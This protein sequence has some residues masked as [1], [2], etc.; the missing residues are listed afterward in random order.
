MSDI[1]DDDEVSEEKVANLELVK[2]YKDAVSKLFNEGEDLKSIE[3]YKN[4]TVQLLLG[5]KPEEVTH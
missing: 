3:Q 4:T 2:K 1:P 5:V